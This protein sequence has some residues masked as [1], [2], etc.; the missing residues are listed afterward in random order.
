MSSTHLRME[1][2]PGF[3]Q[4][5]SRLDQEAHWVEE[6]VRGVLLCLQGLA[7]FHGA[8]PRAGV[9]SLS[10]EGH[11]SPGTTAFSRAREA[12]SCCLLRWLP[13]G[14]GWAV[15]ELRC[16]LPRIALVLRVTRSC[17]DVLAV[18]GAP[19][20]AQGLLASA[21]L[22]GSGFAGWNATQES[23]TPE[24]KVA[25]T[26]ES[27]TVPSSEED[28]LSEPLG[29]LV[30]VSTC[31]PTALK[32]AHT[33]R[34]SPRGAK[35][36]STALTLWYALCACTLYYASGASFAAASNCNADALRC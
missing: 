35:P 9:G 18:G 2:T 24:A 1:D 8:D 28:V 12:R 13:T 7:H 30:G 17:G 26:L 25:V 14:R 27:L 31:L 11:P 10:T 20:L 5:L 29:H 16:W 22:L 19:S 4:Q 34:R 23:L 21:R 15:D 3:Y 36:Y 33:R 6:R 32:P